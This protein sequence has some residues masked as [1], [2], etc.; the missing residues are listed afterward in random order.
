MLILW[1]RKI[2]KTDS[3]TPDADN[4]TFLKHDEDM[5]TFRQLHPALNTRRS[6]DMVTPDG[7]VLAAVQRMELSRN[8]QN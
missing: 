8:S 2:K 3:A 1:I 6:N 4:E 7:Q 5:K